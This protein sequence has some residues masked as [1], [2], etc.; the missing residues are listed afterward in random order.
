MAD[1]L[2]IA[3]GIAGFLSLGI[4]VT[5]TLGGFYAVYKIQDTNVAKVTQNI[6]GFQ[7]SMPGVDSMV[8][9]YRQN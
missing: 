7:T 1:P 9:P 8:P 5:Q 2:S 6:K 3:A 4:H